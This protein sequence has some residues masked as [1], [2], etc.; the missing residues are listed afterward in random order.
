MTCNAYCTASQKHLTQT[1][2]WTLPETYICLWHYIPS[3][4]SPQFEIH[5]YNINCVTVR[6]FRLRQGLVGTSNNNPIKT[7]LSFGKRIK[8]CRARSGEYD[9]VVSVE[10]PWLIYIRSFYRHG[11]SELSL[12]RGMGLSVRLRPLQCDFF[13]G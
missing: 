2:K 3:K 1:V 7:F 9:W 10:T 12:I 6:C 8:S 4:Y 13:T 11:V 5:N